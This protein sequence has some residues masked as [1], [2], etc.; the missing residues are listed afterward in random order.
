MIGHGLIKVLIKVCLQGRCSYKKQG[1]ALKHHSELSFG[2]ANLVAPSSGQIE[3]INMPK[4][5]KKTEPPEEEMDE[6]GLY[7][8]INP[9]EAK[10]HVEALD[11]MMEM[12]CE[13]MDTNDMKDFTET[14]IGRI[15][16]IVVNTL[17]SM[18][19]AKVDILIRAMKDHDFKVLLPRSDKVDQI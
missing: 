11:E 16:E 10:S 13:N 1:L 15:K 9:K 17:T 5:T 2:V 12:I 7:G 19:D 6:T 18:E 8:V 14:V 3:N 4:A